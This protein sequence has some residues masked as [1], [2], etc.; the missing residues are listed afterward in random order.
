MVGQPRP[1]A[2]VVGLGELGGVFAHGLLRTGH[3]VVPV[4]RADDP[5]A[6][7]R[8]VPQPALVAV[9]VGEDDLEGVL[10]ALPPTW[11][12]ALLLVQNELLPRAWSALRAEPT[13]AVV[14]FEKKKTTPITPILS[15]PVVGPRS[16]TVLAALAALDIPAKPIADDARDAALVAKNLYILT[17]NLAG[18]APEVPPGTSVGELWMKHR[19]RAETVAREVLTLQAALLGA[20]VDVDARL[21]DLVRAI[22]ADPKHGARGRTAPARLARALRQA[23]ALGV[24]VPTLRALASALA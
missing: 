23:D 18:L 11:H 4:R 17:A 9:T 12:D 8:E 14:W 16:A 15:T 1:D 13:V 7:A 19:A 21:S 20:P 6:V 2:V 22:D 5:S 10:R 24:E 3:R